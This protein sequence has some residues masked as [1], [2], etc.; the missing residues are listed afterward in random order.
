MP[1][2]EITYTR[3]FTQEVEAQVTHADGETGLL[4]FNVWLSLFMGHR[5]CLKKPYEKKH[6]EGNSETLLHSKA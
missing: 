6:P 5:F 3:D 2:Y 4:R 1:Y